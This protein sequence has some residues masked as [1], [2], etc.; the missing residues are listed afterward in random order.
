MV[1]VDDI[2]KNEN[3]TP[4]LLMG[5]YSKEFKAMYNGSILHAYT[6]DDVR[7]IVETYS[8]VG[9]SSLT[10]I[11]G[12][13]FLSPVAVRTLLKFIEEA[14]FP[15]ILLSY[16]DTVPDVILSRMKFV[17]TKPVFEVGNFDFGSLGSCIDYLSN[18]EEKVHDYERY[19]YYAENCPVAYYL[20]KTG[21]SFGR[22]R[23]I[24][25]L[26]GAIK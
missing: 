11:D 22:D 25:G 8:G 12:V 7:E 14:T 10:V 6:F 21:S 23:R 1:T 20:E 26:L 4:A 19:L 9:R 24:L 2:I 17:L 16:K 15:I 3:Y 5:G 13:G 18:Q